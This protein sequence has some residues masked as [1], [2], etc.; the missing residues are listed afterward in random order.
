MPE[1]N[2]NPVHPPI[3]ISASATR[4][5][6]AEA[7]VR[8]GYN[9]HGDAHFISSVDSTNMWMKSTAPREMTR[10]RQDRCYHRKVTRSGV[11]QSTLSS[12]SL[13]TYVCMNCD[14]ITT[15][16]VDRMTELLCRTEDE[17]KALLEAML[18]MA[19]SDLS[20]GVRAHG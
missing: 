9:Y 8:C 4:D 12:A 14:G 10:C 1:E 2:I 18:R 6:L 11:S 19:K 16:E 13:W 20:R 15:L 5:I 7:W 3:M 17:R